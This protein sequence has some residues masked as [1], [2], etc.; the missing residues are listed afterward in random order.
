MPQYICTKKSAV[1]KS[2]LAKKEQ[3]DPSK[4]KIKFVIECDKPMGV[5]HNTRIYLKELEMQ[6]Q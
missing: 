6:N 3:T 5:K 4:K 1:S 2:N